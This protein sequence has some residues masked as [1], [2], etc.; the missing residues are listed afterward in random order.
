[1]IFF[2]YFLTITTEILAHEHNPGT[3]LKRKCMT[4]KLGTFVLHNMRMNLENPFFAHAYLRRSKIPLCHLSIKSA[5][6][7]IKLKLDFKIK[8]ETMVCSF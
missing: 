5:K 7:P 8:G 6:Y 2:I 3:K 4:L 1:M